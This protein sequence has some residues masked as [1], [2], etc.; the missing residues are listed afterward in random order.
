MVN[1]IFYLAALCSI[2]GAIGVVVSPNPIHSAMFLVMTLMSFAV[3]YILLGADLAAAVQVIVYAS[4]IVILF[5]FV[6]MLLGVDK[7]E[8]NAEP[9]IGQRIIASFVSIL[10]ALTLLFI[11]G[12]K[13]ASGEKSVTGSLESSKNNG[14]GN[15]EIVSQ[16]LFTNYVFVFELT[17]VLLI[18]AVIGAVVLARR[19]GTKDEDL[20]DS[21]DPDFV[22][23]F[24]EI[25]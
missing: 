13:W 2:A 3:H 1:V 7:R 17:G 19:S 18:G 25:S 15:V 12:L 5:L 22:K 20:L 23:D 8:T 21:Q 14:L 9:L 6:I 11:G 10:F 24:E 16:K 4:A